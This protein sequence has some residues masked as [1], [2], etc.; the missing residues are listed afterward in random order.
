M[1]FHEIVI[2][3]KKKK[4]YQFPQKKGFPHFPHKSHDY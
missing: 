2:I 4:K 3:Q 1:L